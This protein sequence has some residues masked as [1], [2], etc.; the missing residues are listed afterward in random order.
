MTT[1]EWLTSLS[2]APE[3]SDMLTVVADL[4]GK[5]IND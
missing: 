4:E 5:E 2:S 3:G 1:G